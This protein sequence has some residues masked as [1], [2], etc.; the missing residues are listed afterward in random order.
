VVSGL[1]LGIDGAAHSGA[2]AA[3]PGAAPPVAVVGSG[4]DVIYPWRHRKLWEQVAEAGVVLSEAPLGA[5]PEPWR[6]PVR[7]RIIASLAEVIVVVESFHTGG[8]RHTV[9]AAAL[10]GRTVMAVPGPVRSQASELP[11]ALLAEG[12]P[13]ARDATDVVVALG[14]SPTR[15]PGGVPDA[16]AAP[17]PEA[18]GVLEA[19]GWERASF[20]AVVLA[21]GRSP[22]EVSLALMHLERDGWVTGSAGWW[23]RTGSAG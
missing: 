4:L 22:A 1:A 9:E 7:N 12:C 5:R 17:T 16:R 14:L 21:S 19:V 10:R 8:S 15:P 13:P 20:E 11:N 18:A 2:L 23:E 3:G 6:F